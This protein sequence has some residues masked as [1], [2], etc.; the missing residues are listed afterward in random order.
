MKQPS[1]SVI[2]DLI[3][4][5]CNFKQSVLECS[6]GFFMAIEVFYGQMLSEM[7]QMKH[8]QPEE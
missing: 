3:C 7:S 2:S 5:S 4:D 1:T 6:V 8:F